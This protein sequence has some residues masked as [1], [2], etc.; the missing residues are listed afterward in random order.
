MLQRGTIK[1]GGRLILLSPQVRSSEL[2]P[3]VFEMWMAELARDLHRLGVYFRAVGIML[4]IPNIR[5]YEWTEDQ[6]FENQ[7][8]DRVAETD[9][10]ALLDVLAECLQRLGAPAELLLQAPGG[11]EHRRR[12]VSE[13]W[14][15]YLDVREKVQH[16]LQNIVSEILDELIVRPGMAEID[17][18]SL[19]HW[20]DRWR[21][22]PE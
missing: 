1:E 18:K 20:W 22:E 13:E 17:E 11:A 4:Q 19:P 21:P 5:D 2:L 12:D 9:A 16:G 6:E 3:Q 7:A 8:G 14:K 15:Q 10:E